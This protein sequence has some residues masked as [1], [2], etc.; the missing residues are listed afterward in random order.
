MPENLL[1]AVLPH[2][3]RRRLDRFLE[4]VALELM[5][6]LIEADEPIEHVFFPY[7]AVTST[8]QEMRD[9]STIEVGLMG[10]EGFIGV[11]FWLR[12]RT[13]P[14]RTLIQVGAAATGWRWIPSTGRSCK[15]PRRSMT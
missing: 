13:T 5:D 15:R 14:S 9:G 2:A 8:V 7:D 12:S 3:E 10:I 11:Q 4:P 6:V 1:L